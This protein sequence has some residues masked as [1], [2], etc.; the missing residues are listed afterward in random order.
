M[1]K[2]LVALAVMA[3]AGAA[4]AQSSVTIYGILD[5]GYTRNG[6]DIAHAA[7]LSNSTNGLGSRLGFRGVEDLG[8]GL[9]AG[10]VLETGVA[11]DS[12]AG[13]INPSTNN[14]GGSTVSGALQFGRLSY[15]NMAGNFGEIRLG[16]DVN[17]SYYN[18]VLYDPFGGL[19]V[20]GGLNTVSGLRTIG[21][22]NLLRSSNAISYFLPSGLLGGLTGQIQYAMGENASNA[23]V[24][25]T[26]IKKDGNYA[27]IRLGY[28]KGP[29]NVAVGYGKFKATTGN[30]GYSNGPALSGPL[31][32]GLSNDRA[33]TQ[34]GGT[35]DFGVVKLW[36][37]FS[38]MEQDNAGLRSGNVRD[39]ETKAFLL[40]ITAPVG[41][42]LIRASYSQA[43]D[44][45]LRDDKGKKFGIGYQYNLSKRTALF[46]T[47]ARVKNEGNAAGT[48]APYTTA[49]LPSDATNR[50]VVGVGSGVSGAN[51]SSTGYD[52]GL[53]HS[54]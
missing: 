19:S 12:G 49:I 5:V 1:K 33:E 9:K 8:N 53:R 48:F 14:Q 44:S 41:P 36:L 50:A 25:T 4:S 29:L 16:R 47:V 51:G 38:K 39:L 18:D 24:G 26:N 30:T 3:A 45:E 17:A 11:N 21:T 37:T 13:N 43:K 27:G 7:G 10:F 42:G 20:A 31:V 35:Y 6:G 22:V 40:G 52:L 32:A 46:V 2:S 34:I 54:F 28:A 23:T 15:V